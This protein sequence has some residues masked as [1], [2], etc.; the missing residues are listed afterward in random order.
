MPLVLQNELPNFS[1]RIYDWG[2]DIPAG[3]KI[4]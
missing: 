3:T 2:K 1:P 4:I